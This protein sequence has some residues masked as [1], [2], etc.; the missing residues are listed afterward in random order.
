LVSSQ[1]SSKHTEKLDG[2]LRVFHFVGT[3]TISN[4]FAENICVPTKL[5]RNRR[6]KVSQLRSTCPLVQ[7]ETAAYAPKKIKKS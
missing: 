3:L 2:T 5:D 6:D 7:G 4:I 1:E